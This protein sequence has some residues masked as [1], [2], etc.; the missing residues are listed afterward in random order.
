WI[1][2]RR[3][4]SS[5]SRRANGTELQDMIGQCLAGQDA[6]YWEQLLSLGGVPAA[7]ADGS[8]PLSFLRSHGMVNKST[9]GPV[10][11][12]WRLHAPYSFSECDSPVGLACEVGE[13]SRSILGW[14]GY[15]GHDVEALVWEGGVCGP[16]LK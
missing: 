8:D 15:G 12:Y 10:G 4:S 1:T 3:F 2:D 5:A 6:G 11:E 16:E 13:H 14:L 9:Y 7:R